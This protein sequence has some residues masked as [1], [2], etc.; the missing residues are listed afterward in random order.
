[1]YDLRILFVWMIL[2]ILLYLIA[3]RPEKSSER[4]ERKKKLRESFQ[5]DELPRKMAGS[6]ID[7][8][9]ENR[10]KEMSFLPRF[11]ARSGAAGIARGTLPRELIVSRGVLPVRVEGDVMILAMVNPFD[12]KTIDE[13]RELTGRIILPVEITANDFGIVVKCLDDVGGTASE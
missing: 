12:L 8:V 6:S 9:I 5:S 4:V 1:M 2:G 10:L 11:D 13:V 7:T 3:I